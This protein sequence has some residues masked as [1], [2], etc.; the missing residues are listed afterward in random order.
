MAVIKKEKTKR[1]IN[2]CINYYIFILV[3]TT[4]PNSS[5]SSPMTHYMIVTRSNLS[6]RNLNIEVFVLLS[7]I[8]QD[9]LIL[10]NTCFKIQW[11]SIIRRI[12]RIFKRSVEVM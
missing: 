10:P 5:T 7:S 6:H 1:T 8:S 3:S 9:S 12:Q 4:H 11:M 2:V